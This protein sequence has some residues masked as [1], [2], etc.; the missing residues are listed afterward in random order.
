MIHGE[1]DLIPIEA[2]R[3]WAISIPNARL[4]C[5]PGVGHFPHLEA[6]EVFFP[7]VQGFLNGEWPEGAEIVQN[8]SLLDM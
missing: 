8:P 7:S 5:I 4:L 6:P 2:A 1:E 3:E